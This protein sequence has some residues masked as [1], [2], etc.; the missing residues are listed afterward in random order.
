VHTFHIREATGVLWYIKSRKAGSEFLTINTLASPHFYSL[1]QNNPHLIY[2]SLLSSQT[3]MAI[4]DS[5]KANTTSVEVPV[6]PSLVY[7]GSLITSAVL[8]A[9]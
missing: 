5:F 3:D 6:L 1:Y 9:R 8:L 4:I 2:S 7:S